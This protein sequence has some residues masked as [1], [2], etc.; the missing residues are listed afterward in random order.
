[1]M[2]GM[3]DC[4]CAQEGYEKECSCKCSNYRSWHCDMLPASKV[5]VVRKILTAKNKWC[6]RLDPLNNRDHDMCWESDKDLPVMDPMYHFYMQCL[7]KGKLA[8]DY[9]C[10]PPGAEDI[11][12]P[13][14][15]YMD[16]TYNRWAVQNAAQLR[17]RILQRKVHKKLCILL[18]YDA[19]ICIDHGCS[20][21]GPGARH[22]KR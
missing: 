20:N 12:G 22:R 4:D 15:C 11:A 14:L 21:A 3:C 8:E 9:P 10:A 18:M 6:S 5:F 13:H 19:C 17:E 7:K 1:M 2:D 16:T